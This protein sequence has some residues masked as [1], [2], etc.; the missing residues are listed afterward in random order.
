MVDKG[1]CHEEGLL[2]EERCN[3]GSHLFSGKLQRRN[4][5]TGT[6][7]ADLNGDHLTL[8]KRGL[9]VFADISQECIAFNP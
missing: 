3:V 2:H 6:F 8:S 9:L 5:F 4:P 7:L 1:C